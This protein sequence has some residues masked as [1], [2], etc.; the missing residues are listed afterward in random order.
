MQVQFKVYRL[1]DMG[2]GCR[3][4]HFQT[5]RG[6][7]QPRRRRLRRLW[8]HR[9]GERFADRADRA[10]AAE[11]RDRTSVVSGKGVS[12]RVDLGGRRIIK[13][14]KSKTKKETTI[15]M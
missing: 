12:V 5:D 3:C 1:T 2:C 13:T 6:C 15:R 14:K 8:P 10:R 4:R 11:Q 7:R 9:Q